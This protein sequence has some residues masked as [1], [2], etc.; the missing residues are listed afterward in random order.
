MNTN[1]EHV[2]YYQ[3]ALIQLVSS[4]EADYRTTCGKMLNAA[5][6]RENSD[7]AL[8]MFF[9]AWTCALAP[10]WLDDYSA[11]IQMARQAV[12]LQPNNQQFLSGL[13]AI[14]L[15]AGQYDEAHEKL[16][17]AVKADPSEKASP[18]YAAYLLA[19]AEYYRGDNVSAK[20]H[21][22]DA[23]RKARDELSATTTI[24]WNR[25]LTLELFQ[26]EAEFLIG[27]LHE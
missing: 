10:G 18:A 8:E 17:S 4:A 19:I 13:G 12:K 5:L 22:D 25:K 20:K 11:P 21:L 9:T 15:R 27:N 16:V 6:A 1:N 26:D 3:L 24:P 23:N 2:A 14:L 7:D